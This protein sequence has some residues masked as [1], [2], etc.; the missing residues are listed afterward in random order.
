MTIKNYI[1]ARIAVF[2]N[3]QKPDQENTVSLKVNLVLDMH[4]RLDELDH[5]L[6]RPPFSDSER[7]VIVAGSS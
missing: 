1:V 2:P 6:R 5:L 7:L 3:K 4:D